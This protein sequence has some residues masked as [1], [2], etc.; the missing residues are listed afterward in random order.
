[1]SGVFWFICAREAYPAALP[2]L[3]A[4]QR[5]FNRQ[6]TNSIAG[7][8]KARHGI[9]DL[10]ARPIS[11]S[12]RDHLL[13]DGSAVDRI[14]F[15]QLFKEIGTEWGAG[16][17]LNTFNLPTLNGVA[18]PI[19]A[20]AAIPVQTVTGATVST[21]GTV[22][23]PAAPGTSG[24]STGGNVPSGGRTRTARTTGAQL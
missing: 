2:T 1:M 24:G 4:D 15:P 9:G 17:G 22:T 3:A 19:P 8:K 23:Q 14:A 7:L 12:I 13:C 6:A 20:P 10:L 5:S 11:K 21:G 16:D 18:L